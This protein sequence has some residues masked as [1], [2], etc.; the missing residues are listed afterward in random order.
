MATKKTRPTATAKDQNLKEKK[1]LDVYAS[2]GQ[3][4]SITNPDREHMIAEAADYIAAR[5]GFNGG[6]PVQDWI[7]AERQINRVVTRELNR[8]TIVPRNKFVL[9]LQRGG[10]IRLDRVRQLVLLQRIKCK[11]RHRLPQHF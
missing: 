11:M 5:R 3:M 9:T 6:D 8:L 7:Q 4:L 10:L 2:S 1:P